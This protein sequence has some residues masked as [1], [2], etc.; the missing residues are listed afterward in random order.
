MEEENPSFRLIATMTE[1]KGSNHFW[2]GETG[3]I[4]K[5]MLA[6]YT[7]NLIRPIYYAAGPPNM[8]TAMRKMLSDDA[9]RFEEFSGY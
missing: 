2:R 3:H 5:E 1:M 4:D 7:G 9:I 6:R 8:V